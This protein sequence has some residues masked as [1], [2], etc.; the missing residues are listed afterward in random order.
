MDLTGL[1]VAP[2]RDT[3][4]GLEE[5]VWVVCDVSRGRGDSAGVDMTLMG[6]STGCQVEQD[7][8]R[9]ATASYGRDGMAVGNEGMGGDGVAGRLDV[10][11]QRCR[12]EAA[13]R[14]CR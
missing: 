14:S 12:G 13:Q 4:V 3:G 9:R 6:A 7:A 1:R 8:S 2:G 5:R 11:T 10:K